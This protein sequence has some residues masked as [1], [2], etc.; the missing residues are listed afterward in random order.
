MRGARARHLGR[1]L[2]AR[3]VH[4]EQPPDAHFLRR[5]RAATLLAHG[6]LQHGVGARGRLV[7]GRGLLRALPVASGEELHD[8]RTEAAAGGRGQERRITGREG[9]R[10]PPPGHGRQG[11]ERG[12]RL[13]VRG[14]RSRRIRQGRHLADRWVA[15]SLSSACG[16]HRQWVTQLS[17]RARGSPRQSRGAGGSPE[18]HLRANGCGNQAHEPLLSTYCVQ[19]VLGLQS[20]CGGSLVWSLLR[21]RPEA[22]L[23]RPRPTRDDAEAAWTPAASMAGA[24]GCH[25]ARA[26]GVRGSGGSKGVGGP[27]GQCAV[28]GGTGGAW[29][30]GKQQWLQKPDSCSA[31]PWSNSQGQDRPSR[32]WP[33]LREQGAD[34]GSE[35]ARL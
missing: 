15:S 22:P 20:T 10:A 28:R 1:P 19:A 4:H 26:R 23:P 13:P 14:T 25:G 21:A 35:C 31:L 34:E 3:Q 29:R 8:L 27:R 9:G 30:Q 17:P 5:G 7:G 2:R 16:R 33:R 18:T 11:L 32:R 12:K 6:D 24:H